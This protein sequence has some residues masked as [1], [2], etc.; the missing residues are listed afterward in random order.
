MV[1]EVF[2]KVYN[3]YRFLHSIIIHSY[4]EKEFDLYND[5]S[6]K[7][8]YSNQIISGV[9][10]CGCI[11]PEYFTINEK[12]YFESQNHNTCLNK[13][14]SIDINGNIK[15]CPSMLENF[16]NIKN[17]EIKD[18]INKPN[19][20]KYWNI[21]KDDIAVCKDCEFR[22]ICTDCR[23]YLENPNDIYSKPLKCGYNPYNNH[24]DEWA[25]NPLKQKALEFYDLKQNLTANL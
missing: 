25:S 17:S 4:L 19:F 8:I 10:N 1:Y 22:H 24:W 2:E 5:N 16:G 12:H 13:K 18:V 11:S 20:K 9:N 21:K 14:L 3:K 15:N 23:A 6:T 7:I